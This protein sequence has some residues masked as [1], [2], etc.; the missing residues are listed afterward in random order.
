MKFCHSCGQQVL[1]TAR[2][3]PHCGSAQS[4]QTVVRH[5]QSEVM[6]LGHL[7]LSF[8]GRITRSTYWL[9]FALPLYFIYFLTLT[10]DK[11]GNLFTVFA[12]L[13]IWP[14]LAVGVKRCH[15][16]DRSGLFLF[17]SLIPV[18]NLWVAIELGLLRGTY[19]S[20]QYGSDPL[21]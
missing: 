20:N 10:L 5:N 17:L 15:D 9:K 2:A 16:R 14:S 12:F 8:N 11:H 13:S 1:M 3:C 19:G 7:L 6:T 18:L 4:T 21:Y